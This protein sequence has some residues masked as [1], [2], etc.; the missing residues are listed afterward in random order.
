MIFWVISDDILLAARDYAKL[1][2]K[3]KSGWKKF[4]FRL[5][6]LNVDETK[7]EIAKWGKK[8]GRCE[9]CHAPNMLPTFCECESTDSNDEDQSG[10]QDNHVFEPQ[11]EVVDITL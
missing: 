10:F 8:T 1:A 9:V 7:A 4:F 3:F 2:R 11:V 6:I 5:T